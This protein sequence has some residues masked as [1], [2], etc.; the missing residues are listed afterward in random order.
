MLTGNVRNWGRPRP[1]WWP[2]WVICHLHGIECQGCG[3]VWGSRGQ[4]LYAHLIQV[5]S[6]ELQEAESC[7]AV[8]DSG[9]AIDSSH[10]HSV[11]RLKCLPS[12][13]YFLRCRYWESTLTLEAQWSLYVPPCLTFTIL[14]SAHTAVF[15]CF[16]WISEQTTII[17]LY[18]IN[19][20]VFIAETDCVY[21]AVRTGCLNV[22]Q[23]NLGPPVVKVS[24]VSF[25][26]SPF[27]RSQM[28]CHWT[29]CQY[30][31]EGTSVNETFV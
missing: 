20:L 2:C 15:M 14:R 6:K 11:C 23:A 13:C 16:V 7:N 29:V 9:R 30:G 24:L 19:W 3:T 28:S 31:V 1:S 4:R 18:N 17:S 5:Q 22:I 10:G 21:C 26:L 8:V 25:T 27:H 12:F